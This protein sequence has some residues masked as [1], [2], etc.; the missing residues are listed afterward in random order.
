MRHSQT[1]GNSLELFNTTLFWKLY[2]GTRLMAE[3]NGNNL[4]RLDNPHPSPLLERYGEGS[5]T[6]H[7]LNSIKLIFLKI[8]EDSKNI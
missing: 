2:R 1:A 4:K 3:P 8:N 7:N 5:E 6:S